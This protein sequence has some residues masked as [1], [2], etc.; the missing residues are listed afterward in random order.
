MSFNYQYVDTYYKSCYSDDQSVNS[1]GT[2]FNY[3]YPSEAGYGFGQAIAS[4]SS[5]SVFV[6]PNQLS[7]SVVR[8]CVCI[9]MYL[10]TACV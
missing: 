9:F 1:G 4:S 5:A 10:C 2:H 7:A 6:G 3:G 8:F